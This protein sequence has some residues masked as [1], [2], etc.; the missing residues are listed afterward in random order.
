MESFKVQ[1]PLTNRNNQHFEKDALIKALKD[2]QKRVDEKI[3]FGVT[4]NEQNLPIIDLRDVTHRI[5]NIKI[6]NDYIICDM[7]PI[8][9]RNETL[10]KLIDKYN[11]S[12]SCFSFKPRIFQN[13]D[14][15]LQI[16]SIDL[17]LN[18]S[19]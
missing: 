16:I 15:D 12:N 8:G 17:M 13:I 4:T 19:E 11:L 7:I 14:K 5:D 3:A 6:D 1:I 10:F 2:Y 9:K 18:K